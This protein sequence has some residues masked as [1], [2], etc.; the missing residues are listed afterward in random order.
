M[1]TRN[2]VP[3]ANDEG[4]L[5]TTSKKWASLWSTLVNALTLTSQSVGFTISGGTT[6]KTL[7][8][9]LDA[10]VAGS[11]TG[12]QT[13]SDATISTT[14]ITTNDA[15]TS[16]HGFVVKA[17]APSAGLINVVGIAN[18]ETGYTN[19]ALFDATVPSTQA[20]GDSAATGSAVVAARR[21][22]VHA[23]PA[24]PGGVSMGDVI[25]LTIALGG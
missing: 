10:S 9:A 13:L 20:F 19:K 8:V 6:S 15:S 22:H 16:K 11:N 17:T 23:M 21:D 3:R 24:N 2:I 14:D 1:A 7:T 25:A 18:G 4:G 5:G 12:D